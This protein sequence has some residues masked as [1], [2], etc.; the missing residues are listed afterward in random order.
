MA[1]T[2]RPRSRTGGP[3]RESA[4]ATLRDDAREQQFDLLTATLI[5]LALGV[6]TTLLFR[7]GP[8]GVRPVMPLLRG[9]G[10]AAKWAGVGGYEGAKMGA[11]AARRGASW[12]ADKGEEV[13]DAVPAEEIG[14]SIGEFLEE[15]R[16][17]ISET[18][19]SEMKD[20]RKAIKRQRRKLGV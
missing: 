11:R 17:R 15:A 12:A 6:G 13:W 7:Q 2:V 20:L 3:D 1:T 14:E 18:V 10:K 16:E 4:R 5:G 8:K 9:A 19:E